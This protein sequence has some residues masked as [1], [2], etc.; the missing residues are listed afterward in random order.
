MFSVIL[1]IMFGIQSSFCQ[2]KI[3]DE[4]DF[5]SSCISQVV[6]RFFGKESELYYMYD[7]IGNH[8]YPFTITNPKIIADENNTLQIREKD[9]RLSS[10]QNYLVYST[11]YSKV[12]ETIKKIQQNTTARPYFKPFKILLILPDVE[13]EL[14]IIICKEKTLRLLTSDPQANR[15]ICGLTFDSWNEYTCDFISQMQFPHLLR[16]YNNC[17]F[18]LAYVALIHYASRI[19]QAAKV[20]EV[21]RIVGL[22]LN[23]TLRLIDQIDSP[24]VYYDGY[25]TQM[26]NSYG[27]DIPC[28]T[29]DYKDMVWIVPWPNLVS[30]LELFKLIFKG[31]VWILMLVTLICYSLVW[32][33][34][35][36]I[37]ENNTDFMETFMSLYSLTIF[38]ST[39]RPPSLRVL[40]LLLI[41]YVVYAMHMQIAFT[42]SLVRILTIPQHERGIRTLSELAESEL[43]ICTAPVFNFAKRG[44]DISKTYKKIQEKIL[45]LSPK[46]FKDMVNDKYTFL[47]HSFLVDIDMYRQFVTQTCRHYNFFIDN[48]YG[49]RRSVSFGFG[50]YSH[51]SMSFNKW[52]TILI[53]SGFLDRIDSRYDYVY[54]IGTGMRVATDSIENQAIKLDT[55]VFLF[56]FWGCGL[57][58]GVFIF[59]GEYVYSRH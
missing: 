26:A 21:F 41:F 50:P 15:N 39:H 51:F 3:E 13:M 47:N 52:T 2:L 7:P 35:K 31:I 57:V 4:N 23:M 14:V 46:T 58:T 10:I 20:F 36:L 17:N 30:N 40:R 42:S 32:F 43:T 54:K 24:E 29:F 6:Q 53:E 27:C 11:N 45:V 16:K 5:Q 33:L 25:V 55:V 22:H 12:F 8:V 1:L 18:T 56:L 38:G 28:T 44:V 9:E 49:G 59:F 48:S 37:R 34:V 19:K